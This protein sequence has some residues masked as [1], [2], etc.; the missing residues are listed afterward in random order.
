MLVPFLSVPFLI[1]IQGGKARHHLFPLGNSY[2]PVASNFK[3]EETMV[4]LPRL[5]LFLKNLSLTST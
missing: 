3:R 5:L 4:Q 1:I 2:L